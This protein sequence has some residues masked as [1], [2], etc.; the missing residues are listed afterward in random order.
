[1]SDNGHFR[2]FLDTFRIPLGKMALLL[3]L[4]VLDNDSLCEGSDKLRLTKSLCDK[5]GQ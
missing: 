3:F 4:A 5:Y 2:P 1:M